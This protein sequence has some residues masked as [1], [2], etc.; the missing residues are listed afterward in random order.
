[1]PYITQAEAE[2]NVDGFSSKTQAEKDR[3]LLQSEIY[4]QNK[5][6]PV[7]VDVE[8]V[9]DRIK[10][11]SYEVIRGIMA[12]KLM[13]GQSQSITEKR[14]KAGDVEVQKKFTDGS[15]E[16]NQYEQMI[17]MLIEPFANCSGLNRA[18]VRPIWRW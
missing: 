18:Y 1:M 6:V 12:G 4:L 11:A 10:Q 15:V 13:V 3:L 14:V 16:L 2:L 8:K 17:D 5:C 7:M 9:P